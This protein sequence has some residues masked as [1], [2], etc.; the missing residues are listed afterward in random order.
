MTTVPP[1]NTTALP[2]VAMVRAIAPPTEAP[3]CSS[4]R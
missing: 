1:A 2:E 3:P 4:S